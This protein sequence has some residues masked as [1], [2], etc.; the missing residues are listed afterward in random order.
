M[1]IIRDKIVTSKQQNVIAEYLNNKII[2]TKQ[3]ADRKLKQ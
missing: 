2:I 1:I 3:L